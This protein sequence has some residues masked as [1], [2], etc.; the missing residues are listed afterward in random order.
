MTEIGAFIGTPEYMSP[1]QAE[2]TPLDV[3]TRSDVYSLGVVLYELLVGVLPFDADILRQAGLDGI[4]RTIREIDPPRPSTRLSQMGMQATDDVTRHRRTEVKKLTSQLRGDLDWITLKALEKDRTRRYQTA[5]GLAVD[6]RRHLNDEPVAAGPPSALYRTHKF[7]RRHR[8][9]V[10]AASVVVALLIAFSVTTTVQARKIARERDR[11]NREAFAAKQVSNFLVDLFQ[12]SDPSEARG[13]TLTARE[14]LDVGA[15]KIDHDLR[16]QPEAQ[17][18]LQTTLGRVYTSLGLYGEAETMLRQSAGTSRAVLGERHP[19]T[20]TA[21]DALAD[22][23]WYE[24]KMPE[25][26]LLYLSVAKLREQVLGPH[27]RDTL[28]TKYDLA[29]VY[30]FQNR[31]DEAERLGREVLDDQRKSLGQDDPDTLA[32]INNLQALYFRRQRY[33]EA[34]PLAETVVQAR[35]RILGPDHPDTLRAI[36]N[37]GTVYYG[38]MRLD[39]AER[40]LARAVTGRQ[41]VLGAAHPETYRS[42]FYLGMIY[43]KEG[44]Y[45]DAE[46][47]LASA[48]AGSRTIYGDDHPRVREIVNGLVELYEGHSDQ[49]RASEWR[50]RLVRP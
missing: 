17:A 2:M 50:A 4:R 44:R 25:A 35:M 36:H 34:L 12:V 26:E 1:E 27:H 39:E 45:A 20:L 33:A 22:A 18:R 19:E 15:R 11:A 3:D 8:I 46:A 7:V 47:N 5:N 29:S 42:M 21:Q 31:W 9:G 23:L 32:S 16:E 6:I 48:Y 24:T 41:R 14:I 10:F 13:N 49:A 38:L 43:G 40:L 30:L 28:Q 37:L